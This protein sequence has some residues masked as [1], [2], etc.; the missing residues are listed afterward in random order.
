[1]RESGH[2]YHSISSNSGATRQEQA[3]VQ[4]LQTTQAQRAIATPSLQIIPKSCIYCSILALI[5]HDLPFKI[6]N[7][8]AGAGTTTTAH[9][10]CTLSNTRGSMG[11]YVFANI[12][13]QSLI[14]ARIN[15]NHW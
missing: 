2:I 14:C 7:I 11:E 3:H 8:S 5:L 4:E 6:R 13:Q 9:T 10:T 15:L 1:M 12:T